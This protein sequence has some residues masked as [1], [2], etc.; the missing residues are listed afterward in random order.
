MTKLL[1]SK[2]AIQAKTGIHLIY[3]FATMLAVN[4]LVLMLANNFFPNHVV[5]GTYSISYWWAI[6][7]SMVKLSLIGTL[8]MPLVAHYEWKRGK[9]FEPKEW[10]ITYM[11]VNVVALWGISRFAE[12]LG[13]GISAWWVVLILAAVF[14]WA[15]GMA[16][17]TLGKYLK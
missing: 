11:V 9:L 4:T 14:N 17:M 13:L 15:Q 12:N 16:M 5:L 6:Y 1:M 2:E 10:M 7:H 3:A 8:V